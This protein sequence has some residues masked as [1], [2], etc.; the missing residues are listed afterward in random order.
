MKND[1]KYFDV[2]PVNPLFGLTLPESFYEQGDSAAVGVRDTLQ[3][4]VDQINELKM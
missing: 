1:I 4:T 3:K 2:T